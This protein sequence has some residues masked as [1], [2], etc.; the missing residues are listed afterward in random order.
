MFW[1]I[2]LQAQGPGLAL[3]DI[4]ADA[5]RPALAAQVVAHVQPDVLVLSGLDHDH[6]LVTLSALRD[7]IAQ[8]GHRF[9]HIHAFASNAGLR[10]GLDLNADGRTDTPD[11]AQG[12]GSFT[13]QKGLAVLSQVPINVARSRDFS[14]F[15]W[16]DMPNGQSPHAPNGPMADAQ[17][18]AV[19]RLSST[20]HWDIALGTDHDPL[21]LLIW[22]SGPPAFGGSGPRNYARNHDE[23]AFWTAFLDGH[24]PMSPPDTKFVLMGGTN[25]D[26]F[27][28]D[29]QG[30]ALRTLLVHPSVQ[31]PEPTSTGAV[32]AAQADPRS[33]SHSGPHALD[34]VDWPQ[35]TGPGNLRVS[36]ILPSSKL[37]VQRAGVFW[38]APDNA[39]SALLGKGD[40]APSRHRPVWVDIVWKP[41]VN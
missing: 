17:V 26:P 14:G 29:G 36:Y 34:T 6:G 12:Y 38:P 33:A 32:I 2:D 28:G 40:T 23:T 22:Q 37:V 5:P 30:A 24:L 25:L 27:D 3:R 41:A 15:L 20:G 4:L 13:G 7:L 35:E 39:L 18:H 31:D 10:S 11:D 1:R 21:H 9:D 8:H 19:Q 16:A